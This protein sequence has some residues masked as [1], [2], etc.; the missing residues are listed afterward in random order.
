MIERL[1]MET[2]QHASHQLMKFRSR[3]DI[4]KRLIVKFTAIDTDFDM[5]RYACIRMLHTNTIM[6]TV[7]NATS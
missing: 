6:L 5:S 1:M 4:S 3:I 7:D 2:V